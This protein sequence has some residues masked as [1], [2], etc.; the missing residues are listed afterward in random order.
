MAPT[1]T[2][3]TVI[4]ARWFIL[5]KEQL[6]ANVSSLEDRI[7]RW[8]ANEIGFPSIMGPA[9]VPPDQPMVRKQESAVSQTVRSSSTLA[10]PIEL[11]AFDDEVERQFQATV[12]VLRN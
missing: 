9:G 5:L 2:P 3:T 6:M 10:S 4:G 8:D 11:K 1:T 12:Q 7:E